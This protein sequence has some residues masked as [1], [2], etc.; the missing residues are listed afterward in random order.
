MP[1]FP[2]TVQQ[3]LEPISSSQATHFVPSRSSSFK[4][5]TSVWFV[6]LVLATLV[7]LW[8]FTG[9]S[10]SE[11]VSTYVT[12]C[13]F[14]DNDDGKHRGMDAISHAVVHTSASEDLGTYD[15]PGTMAADRHFLTPGTKVYVP[16][17][18]RY[19]VME[20]TCVKCSRDWM[21]KKLHVDLDVSGSGERLA[22]CE[23]RL[24][25]KATKVIVSPPAG[26]PVKQGL[27]CD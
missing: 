4:R 22:E 3:K 26:L 25:M 16:A 10:R 27:A 23:D 6:S 15:Q 1:A 13:R 21:H 19:Y 12:F 24:T 14:D 20:E 8:F 11:E 7:A 18:R 17:V 5:N 9:G 2:Q